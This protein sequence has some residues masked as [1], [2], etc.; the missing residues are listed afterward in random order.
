M[1]KLLS[2]LI[3]FILCLAGTVPVNAEASMEEIYDKELEQLLFPVLVQKMIRMCWIIL[4]LQC[5]R[6]IWLKH[7]KAI[8][9]L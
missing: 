5:L 7:M 3:A 4:K 9:S 2:A 1:K 6:N 8:S